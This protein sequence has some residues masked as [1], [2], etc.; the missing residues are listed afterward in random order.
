MTI[1]VRLDVR[2]EAQPALLNRQYLQPAAKPSVARPELSTAELAFR[3]FAA[4]R[5]HPHINNVLTHIARANWVQVEQSLN[6]ILDVATESEG[7]SPLE[8]NIVDLMVAERG[9]T[10]K[11]LKPCFHAVL[12]RLLARDRAEQLICHIEALFFEL[13]WKAQRPPPAT[14]APSE[15]SRELDDAGR[16]PQ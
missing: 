2:T 5:A 15:S 11:I 13:E 14:P 10:G 1:P 9:V 16:G 6:R 4:F 8:Q 3:I 7:L 12:H